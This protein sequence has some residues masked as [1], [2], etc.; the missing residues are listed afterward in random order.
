MK[1]CR[2]CAILQAD[3]S[4][5][6]NRSRQEQMT[7]AVITGVSSGLGRA[8][9]EYFTKQG[10][11]VYGICRS[12]PELPPGAEWIRADITKAED[13]R[14][15]RQTLEEK[16]VKPDIL[17]NNAGKG[18]YATW[19]EMPESDLRE[20]MELDFFA[21]VALTKE[22]LPLLAE[23][24]GTV[25]NVSS[26]AGRI[27]VPCMGGYCAA[28]AAV[29]MFS[30]SLRPEIAKYGIRVLDVAPG[31]ISTGFSSRSCGT[32]RPPDSPGSKGHTAQGLAKAVFRAWRKKKKRITYPG[33]LA[34]A[35]WAVRTF[36]PGLYDK[37]NRK[38]WKL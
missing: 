37:I 20:V 22:L 4:T 34:V 23:T 25:I 8:M 38:L 32:R 33:S 11:T 5:V 17:I 18:I 9:A 36:I 6:N 1:K 29:A 21:P 27:W 3:R 16:G 7:T 14:M 12:A 24:E 13:R 30:N 35:V 19:E 26:V 2:G 15:I 10:V 28:K 31:Q